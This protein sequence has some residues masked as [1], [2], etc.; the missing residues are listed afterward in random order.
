[1][2]AAT[3]PSVGSLQLP[4]PRVASLRPPTRSRCASS[5][6]LRP[7]ISVSAPR[8]NWISSP[9]SDDIRKQ[10]GPP[11]TTRYD[12]FDSNTLTKG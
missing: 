9:P 10:T 1:M 7:S 5:S 11:E 8:K 4:A 2:I 6:E 12:E 3:A